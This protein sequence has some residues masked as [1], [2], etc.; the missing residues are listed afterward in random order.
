MDDGGEST[1]KNI[2]STPETLG[3]GNVLAGKASRTDIMPDSRFLEKKLKVRV[4]IM[5]RN[6]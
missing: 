2:E 3:S 6:Y 5:G 4:E 1:P